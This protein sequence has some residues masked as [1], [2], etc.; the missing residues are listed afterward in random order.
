MEIA[1]NA[2]SNGSLGPTDQDSAQALSLRSVSP[3]L[4]VSDIEASLAWYRDIV[5]FQVQE[6]WEDEGKVG[7]VSLLAGMG[8]IFLTQD[9]WAK[10]RDRVKG[11]GLRLHMITD[12]DVDEL[13]AAI[14]R[15]GG[16]LESPPADMPWG[17]RAFSLED[18]D[19]YRITISSEG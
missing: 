17:P 13:G 1:M 3:A 2:A 16:A 6:T 14:E 11:V 19:G 9:D 15:R 18:P 12:Q 10:G 7:G 4:T 8:S 5:G